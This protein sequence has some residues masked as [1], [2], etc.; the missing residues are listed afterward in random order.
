MYVRGREMRDTRVTEG[1]VGAARYSECEVARAFSAWRV[2]F[3]TAAVGYRRIL[4]SGCV[5]EALECERAEQQS[6]EQR[7]SHALDDRMGRAGKI[8]R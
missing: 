2:L 7:S 1:I 8:D 6:C 5:P 3:P 4:I